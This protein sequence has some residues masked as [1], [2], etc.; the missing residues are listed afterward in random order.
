MLCSSRHIPMC[1]SGRRR[2]PAKIRPCCLVQEVTPDVES[3]TLLELG[4]HTGMIH[5]RIQ[6]IVPRVQ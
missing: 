2:Q 3:K 4:L 6:Q 5:L 1:L